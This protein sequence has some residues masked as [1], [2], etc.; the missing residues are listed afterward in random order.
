MDI[1]FT[2]GFHSLPLPSSCIIY[3]SNRF[4][5]RNSLAGIVPVNIAMLHANL[6]RFKFVELTPVKLSLGCCSCLDKK[7]ATVGER[8]DG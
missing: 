2:A 8:F 7:S 5:D 4:F 1:F 6:V 3:N